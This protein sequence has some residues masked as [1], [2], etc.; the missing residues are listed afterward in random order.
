ME[1]RSH[2]L[3]TGIFTIALLVATVLIGLWFNRD[4][5]ELVQYEIVTTQSIPGLNPQATVRYRGL[6]IGR[7][8][9]ID[10]DPRVT[11]QILIRLSVDEASPI[12][13]TTY[14]SLGYQGVTGI[15]FIQLNDER[16]GSPRLATGGERIARIPLRPGLLD[17]LE[18]RG[19]A[20]LD[21]AEKITTSL[22]ELL[23]PENRATMLGAF[24]SVDRAADAYAAIPQRLDPVLDRLPSLITKADRSMDSIDTLATSATSMTRNYDNLATRLQA[25]D[26]P[27]ERLNSTIGALGAATSELEL[28]TLPHVVQMTDEARASL[29]AVRRTAN[30]FSDR[31]QSILFGTPGDAPG[32]GEPGFAPPTK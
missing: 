27:I 20:I 16:T 29:R 18:D 8:D 14:A 4:K 2:A 5:T 6:E 26:G 13:S 25:P 1:N 23:S 31:P 24:E 19:L 15:A 21:K 7:V 22:D 9:T 30:S 32:P 10:F 28:E 17:Q 3:M 11:G 12:T